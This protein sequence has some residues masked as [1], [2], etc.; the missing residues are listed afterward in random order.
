M[1]AVITIRGRLGADP[2]TS[3]LRAVGHKL[4][5]KGSPPS[6]N[7]PK[8]P[9]K[10]PQEVVLPQVTP[11][12]P[13]EVAGEQVVPPTP[14]EK[15][16]AERAGP[17]LGASGPSVNYRSRPLKFSLLIQRKTAGSGAGLV[18][19]PN[20]IQHCQAPLLPK[21]SSMGVDRTTKKQRII[22]RPAQ[23]GQSG[24]R[25]VGQRVRVT[26]PVHT[27]KKQVARPTRRANWKL[28]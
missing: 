13:P 14:S 23:A 7:A 12:T 5:Q 1:S 3:Y 22:G 26:V 6:E 10:A 25:T 8:L 2:V 16:T 24:N 28:S 20:K 4:G 9:V 15:P 21:T 27:G 19:E 18:A 11:Q 17:T